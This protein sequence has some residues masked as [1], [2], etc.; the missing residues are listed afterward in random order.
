[1]VFFKEQTSRCLKFFQYGQ[2]RLSENFD[3]DSILSINCSQWNFVCYHS[4]YGA[5]LCKCS[6]NKRIEFFFVCPP[7]L[8]EK[9]SL[10]IVLSSVFD[11]IDSSVEL[12]VV[13]L[14]LWRFLPQWVKFA[15]GFFFLLCCFDRLIMHAP[16]LVPEFTVYPTNHL[17]HSPQRSFP[18]KF[19]TYAFL[20]IKQLRIISASALNESISNVTLSSLHAMLVIVG[21]VAWLMQ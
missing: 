5:L 21:V 6:L 19:C 2:T 9:L 13:L 8:Q 7:L 4:I 12:F 17:P 11:S 10:S 20:T 15:I 18:K 1:M 3:C 14:Y 16:H